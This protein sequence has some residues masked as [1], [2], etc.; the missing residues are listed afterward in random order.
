[1]RKWAQSKKTR[2]KLDLLLVLV[3]IVFI[4]ALIY[5]VGSDLGL[6]ADGTGIRLTGMAK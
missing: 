3:A 6:Q 4:A 5:I 2:W 1:M